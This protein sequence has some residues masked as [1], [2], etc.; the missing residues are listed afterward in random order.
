[1]SSAQCF[2]ITPTGSGSQ[3]HVAVGGED[4]LTFL[5]S[6][7]QSVVSS[8]DTVLK[9]MCVLV[10]DTSLFVGLDCGSIV[11]VSL[12]VSMLLFIHCL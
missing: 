9:V 11:V 5:S 6:S 12:T 10:V 1:M 8:L 3:H 7:D 2:A 4:R